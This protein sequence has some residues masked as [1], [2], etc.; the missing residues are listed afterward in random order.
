ML[1]DTSDE[2]SVW[3]S[4]YWLAGLC[5]P[6]CRG[7]ADQMT[8]VLQEAAQALAE[9]GV[10]GLPWQTIP[11]MTQLFEHAIARFTPGNAANVE[12]VTAA[13]DGTQVFVTGSDAQVALPNGWAPLA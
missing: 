1:L 9:L 3:R 12:H 5:H 11:D 2:E 8:S 7:S 6:D 13:H 10:G 4:V